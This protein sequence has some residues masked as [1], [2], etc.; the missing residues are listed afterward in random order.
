MLW[1]TAFPLL[2]LAV[3]AENAGEVLVRQ[4]SSPPTGLLFSGSSS[5]SAF[6]YLR[7][8]PAQKECLHS[9]GTSDTFATGAYFNRYKG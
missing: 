7:F 1:L 9:F 6:P 4:P 5:E 3:F 2:I 8:L